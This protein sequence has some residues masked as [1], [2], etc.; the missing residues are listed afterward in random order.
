M[1]TT[2][3]FVRLAATRAPDHCAIVDDRIERSLTYLQLVDQIEAVAA[4]FSSLGINAGDI[5]ATCLGNS[6]EHGLALLA[7]ERLGAIPALI[8]ARLKSDDV[9]RLIEQGRMAGAI[10]SADESIVAAVKDVLPNSAPLMTVGGSVPGSIPGAT[11]F[12][13]SPGPAENLASYARPDAEATAFIFY[14]SGTTGLPKG[15]EI[16]HRATDS[17][18]L[19]MSTQCGLVHGTHNKVL[20]LMPMFHV[21]GFYSV[22]MAALGLDGTY[23]VCSDFSPG[24]A[25]ETIESEGITLLYG[26]PAHFHGILEAP[27]FAPEKVASVRNLIYAGSAMPGPLLDRVDAAFD[28]KIVNIYGTTEIMNALYMADPVGRPLT[29]RPGFYS[30]VRVGRLGG[31]VHDE[32]DAGVDGELLVDASS[33]A[34]FTGYLHRPEE[35]IEKVQDGWYR[36]GDIAV[37]RDD[38]DYDLRGRVDDMINSGGENI[39]PED[40]EAVLLQMDNVVECSVIGEPD[41]KWGEIVVACLVVSGGEPDQAALDRH[42]RASPLADYKRPRKYRFLKE[43]PKNAANKVLRRLLREQAAEMREDVR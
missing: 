13:S 33:D 5:V 28:A 10:V 26:A 3:D 36:T 19:Y 23:Y 32:V 17:R 2:F 24:A 40:I 9:G 22:L 30:S 39:Y 6:Y 35:T 14:T 43:L 8:N 1:Q 4:G 42:L 7:L 11:E 34:N 16:P 41:E 38:G 25:I 29:Y 27:N 18:M 12:E 15:V 37:K 31:S 21:V 20:G